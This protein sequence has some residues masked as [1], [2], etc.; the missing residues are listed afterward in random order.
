LF[1]ISSLCLSLAMY[2]CGTS[3]SLM[4]L[5]LNRKAVYR[6]HYGLISFD[7]PLMVSKEVAVAGQSGFELSGPMGVSRVAWRNQV[8]YADQAVNAWFQPSLPILTEGPPVKP[9][10]GRIVSM[11]MTH[12]ASATLDLAEEKINIG[13]RDHNTQRA[14][15]KVKMDTA[16]IDLVTWYEAGVGMVRQEQSTKDHGVDH[17]VVRIEL[18]TPP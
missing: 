9:W 5:S 8:L 3:R 13:G 2:G 11:G 14:T 15:L 16:R 17:E 1:S 7:E 10:H 12:P 6:V 4:P 18:L